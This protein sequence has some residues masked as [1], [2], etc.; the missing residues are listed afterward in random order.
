MSLFVSHTTIDCHD[1]FALSE[2]W[3]VLL[4]YEMDPED[5]N[6]PG[7]EECAISDPT[8]GHTLLFIE[9]PDDQLPTKRIHLDLRPRERPQDE[10]VRWALAQGATEIADRRG[11]HGPGTGWVVMADPEGNQF[12]VLRSP[13]ELEAAGDGP[14][15]G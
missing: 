11:L 5:P 13:A 7:H 9:V 10:E 3:R 12:C 2:W 15:A 8:T 14:E 1:A 6:F 4:D